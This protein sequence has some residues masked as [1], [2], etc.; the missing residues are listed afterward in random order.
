MSRPRLFLALV[1]ILSAVAAANMRAQQANT[2]IVVGTVVDSSDAP[3]PGATVTLL[4]LATNATTDVVTDERG[5]YRTPPLRIGDYD[6][7]VALPGFRSFSQ[8]GVVLNI[9]DVRTV[10]ATLAIGDV[11]ETVT[12]AADAPLLNL[13]DST[14]GTVITNQQ[15][16]DLPLNGRDYLQLASLTAG[17]APAAGA[18]VSIGG[19]AGT[20]VAFLLDGQDN[21]NQQIST[22]HSG[23]K[24]VVKPSIDAIQEF[25]VVTNGYAA[26]YGRSSS[27]VVSVSLKSGTNALR[28]TL[29]EYFRDEA[30]D[31]KN[32]FATEKPPY[33]RHQ[34][35]GAVGLPLVRNRTFFFG[36]LDSGVIRRSTT[37]VSTLPSA[38]MRA[39]QFAAA[40]RDPLTGQAFA[41][42][43]IP[44]S[45]LDPVAARVLELLPLPQTGASANNFVYNSPSNQDVVKWDARL[46]HILSPNQNVYFRYGYQRTEDAVSSPLPPDARGNYYSGGGAETSV[47]KSWVFVHNAIW[48]PS[49]ISSVRVGW[50]GIFWDNVLPDQALRG[51]GIPGVDARNPGFS[52]IAITG[53]R[54]VGVSNVPNTDDSWNRQVSGDLTWTRGA[55]T[56]KGGVQA[57]LLGIDF[58]SSQRSSGIFNFNGQYTGNAFAD[59]LLGY[60]SSAS[61]S[62]WAELH[63]RAPYSHLFVQDDWRVSRRLTLNL[64]LRYELSLPATDVNDGIANFD[65]DTDPANPR[66][67]LAGSEG[68]DYASRALQRVNYTQ[69]APRAGFAY[70]LPGDRTVVRGGAGIFYSNLITLGG[71][72]SMEINPPHHLRINQTT[73]AAAPTIFLEQGFAEDTLTAARARNVTL[74]SYDRSNRTPTS[75]QWNVNVQRELPGRF[76][77]D[78]GY[79][80][81]RFV[82]DWRQIDGNPAPP[83]PGNINSRRQFTSTLV[84]GTDDAITLA[85]VVRIQ[86]DGWNRYHA[87]QTKVEKRY[88]NGLSVLAAYTLA[89]T[90][91]LGSFFQDAANVAAEVAPAD[92]DR[93]H[94]FVASGLYELPFGISISPILTLYSGSPLNLTVNGNPA[95]TGQNDRPNVVGDWELDNPT[96][97]RWF[98]TDAFAANAPYTYGNAPRNLLRGPGRVNLDVSLRKTFRIS[99]RVGAELRFESFNLTNTPPLGNPNTQVGNVNFGRI[100]EA[101]P[102]RSNQVAVKLTF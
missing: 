49:L 59:F 21:N 85:N 31:A 73:S 27:G 90:T 101:G 11:A 100:S 87:L 12:V 45:R 37:T 63:F 47:A 94:Y 18:G 57:Y 15:I 4:H 19:Q 97:E 61:V 5:Q 70:S 29:Y 40:I 13:S 54:T 82:N 17:T 83:G 28:G 66:I 71:M 25:K 99:P 3:A 79:T 34:F 92:N 24:E 51:I 46:D 69:F 36:D 33:E 7:T 9:G 32:F 53:Y 91:A 35:G 81:N 16:K 67:V 98:D 2:A 14:V 89:K 44:A 23:Q 86:K 6:L 64:G 75:Y 8:R 65:L 1:L 88:D 95:N 26:E 58:L 10:N 55:H 77:V 20:Q 68:G 52:Q 80:G 60:A 62:K 96:V 42:N 22:G 56:I 30:L 76:V 43:R 74:V 78:V 102:A 38:E 39:G 48:S 50:N 72:Q 93:R 84:P 41:G